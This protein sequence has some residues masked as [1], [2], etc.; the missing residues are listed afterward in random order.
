MALPLIQLHNIS[1]KYEQTQALI[2]INLVI[3]EGDFLAI[4]GPNGSGK[5]TLLKIMLGLLKPS[6]GIL[7]SPTAMNYAVLPISTSNNIHWQFRTINKQQ[8]YRQTIVSCGTTS[9]YAISN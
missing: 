3:K 2:D 5:S 1:Y 7:I 8:N 4:I 9:H 6:N